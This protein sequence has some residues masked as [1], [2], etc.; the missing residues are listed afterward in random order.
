MSEVYVGRGGNVD[1]ALQK[2]KKKMMREGT[3]KEARN[4]RFYEK[5][6]AIKY[7]ERKQALLTAKIEARENKL[8][9]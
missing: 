9:Q 4:R 1:K 8:W 7:R 6:S 2:L 3:I 5:P